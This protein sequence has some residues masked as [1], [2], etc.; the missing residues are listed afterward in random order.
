MEVHAHTHTPRKK[1]THYFWEFLMLFLAV[2]CGFF[3]EYQLEHTIEHQREK[4]YIRSMIEDAKTDTTNNHAAIDFNL[5]RISR[6][7][8]LAAKCFNYMQTQSNDVDLFRLFY[9]SLRHPDFVTPIERT[10]T[11]LKNAGG[12]RLIRRKIA[13]DSILLYDDFAKKLFNQQ[14][15]YEHMLRSIIEPGIQIF[16]FKHLP[17]RDLVTFK[18][19]KPEFDSMKINNSQTS[20]VELGNRALL[21]RN[22]VMYYVTLL[23]EGEIHAINLIQT[24]ER[25]Y[26]LK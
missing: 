11:Q 15:W 16:N 22:I 2:F 8:S 24:L 26:H 18:S 9:I 21:Y 14:E 1:W 19:A 6:L 17:K 23:R 10:M 20:L 7:D 12:M 3:A 13:A 4:E 5:T 25:E